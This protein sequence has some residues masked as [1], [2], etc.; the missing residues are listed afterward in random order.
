MIDLKPAVGE[1]CFVQ[2]KRPT[3]II[4]KAGP[5]L[6]PME[7]PHEEDPCR[8]DP[9]GR[10]PMTM[11]GTVVTVDYLIG[12]LE[13]CGEGYAL[14]YVEPASRARIK[15]LLDPDSVV[16]CFVESRIEVAKPSDLL[17]Q[18]ASV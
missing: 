13:H 16:A 4:I 12:K 2:L 11:P 7:A 18:S 14:N 17:D 5:G 10:T 8:H 3:Y 6:M 1:L 9:T 15:V